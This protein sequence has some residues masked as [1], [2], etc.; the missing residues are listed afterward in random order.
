MPKQSGITVIETSVSRPFSDAGSRSLLAKLSYTR[1]LEIDGVAED[2]CR[3]LMIWHFLNA[4]PAEALRVY[5]RCQQML[6][7]IVGVA[8]TAETTALADRI[9]AQSGI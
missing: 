1:T 8:P 3:R 2:V 9:R 6:S 5:R 7:Q 4:Q